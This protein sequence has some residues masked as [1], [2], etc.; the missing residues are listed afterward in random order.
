MLV[1]KLYLFKRYFSRIYSECILFIS[2]NV[3]CA[4][5]DANGQPIITDDGQ[6]SVNLMETQPENSIILTVMTSP[7][8]KGTFTLN[9]SDFHSS[10]LSCG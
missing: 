1:G 9:D 7:E 6:M 4:F 10:S 2:N 8:G 3:E 5:L